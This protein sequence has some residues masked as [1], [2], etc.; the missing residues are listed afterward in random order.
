MRYLLLACLALLVAGC[1][2]EGMYRVA[3]STEIYAESYD[4]DLGN[5][6]VGREFDQHGTT[7]G[8]K[9]NIGALL[10]PQQVEVVSR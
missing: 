4:G 2:G 7:L 8:V 1:T 10:G 5:D 9:I 6:R 3:R